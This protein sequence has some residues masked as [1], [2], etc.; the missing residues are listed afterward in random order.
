MNT[1][2]ISE[3]TAFN[4]V[5]YARLGFPSVYYYDTSQS[6]CVLPFKNISKLASR[7]IPSIHGALHSE[8]FVSVVRA[9]ERANI[10]VTLTLT[11]EHKCWDRLQPLRQA[12]MEKQLKRRKEGRKERR[13]DGWRNGL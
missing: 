12:K 4:L 9:R 8:C 2:V 6:D 1:H 11:S 3:E 13:K 5:H 10:Q 7:S